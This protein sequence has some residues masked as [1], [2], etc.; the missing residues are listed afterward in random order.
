MSGDLASQFAGGGVPQPQGPV[1]AGRGD[2]PAIGGEREGV[3]GAAVPQAQAAQ[4][5]GRAGRQRVA[6]G[7]DGRRLVA[8][9][10][11]H[12]Q[13]PADRQPTDRASPRHA[14]SPSPLGGKGG[15]MPSRERPAATMA[16]SLL[17]LHGD[18][19]CNEDNETGPN[20]SG[21][22]TAGE[23]PRSPHPCLFLASKPAPQAT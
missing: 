14:S 10:L 13:R 23:R 3:Q 2:R 12:Q 7:I 6:L 15:V 20:E 22:R 8:R 16:D 4:P 9:R 11:A 19:V 18:W 17:A 5:Q 21:G 1:V